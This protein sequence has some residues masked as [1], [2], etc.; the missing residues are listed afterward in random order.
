MLL[1]SLILLLPACPAHASVLR[2]WVEM[3]PGG[4]ALVRAVVD[5]GACPVASADGREL[6]LAVRVGPDEAFPVTVCEAQAPSG[7]ANVTVAGVVL[8]LPVAAP[9]RIVVLGDSGCRLV[10]PVAYQ[11]CNDPAAF[12]LSRLAGMAAAMNPDLIL[13]VGDY[14]YREAACPPG[15]MFDC[16]GSPHGDT[17][18]AWDADWFGPAEPLLH[19]APLA[20][21]RGNHE[22]CGRG[23]GGWFRLLDPYPYQAEAAGC[24]RGSAFDTEAPY[25]VSLG[26]ARLLMFDSSFANDYAA[27]NSAKLAAI[28]AGQLRAALAEKGAPA[29][30]ATHRPPFGAIGVANGVI[31]GGNADLQAALQAVKPDGI[32]LFLS[33]HIHSFEA[34]MWDAADPA[35]PPQLVV[36]TGGTRLDTLK[37]PSHLAGTAFA[38][39]PGL[40]PLRAGLVTKGEFGFAVLDAVPGGYSV[41]QYDL[42]GSVAANCMIAL[43]A[44]RLTCSQ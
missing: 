42:G 23:Q 43:V 9:R 3:A 26:A 15:G 35:Y 32:G 8:R 38:P 22:S 34:L 25:W 10:A 17:W 44:R 12:P 1:I 36:G 24:A 4:V 18:A 41:T 13:H 30:L 2:S 16:E 7:A 14:Y 29:I 39:A 21:S 5:D 31:A 19:A 33:G 37:L 20:F 28:Y 6:P 27:A 40:D 11:G